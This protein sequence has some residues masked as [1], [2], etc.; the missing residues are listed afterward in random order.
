[1]FIPIRTPLIEHRQRRYYRKHRTRI[2]ESNRVKE[3][4]RVSAYTARLAAI[5]L[6]SGCL[7]CGGRPGAARLD[8][9]HRDPTTKRRNV[10]QM[11]LYA[12]E[13]ILA[14]IEKCDVLCKT[15]HGHVTRNERGTVFTNT[16]NP[17][18]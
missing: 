8:F 13:A 12:E 10:S 16:I 7:R 14:E 2:L 6:S 3:R 15:C 5:K 4:E 18:D 17:E 9:H 1:M 11:A